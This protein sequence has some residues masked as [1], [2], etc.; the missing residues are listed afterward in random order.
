MNET[1]QIIIKAN[2]AEA[3]K[4][5]KDVQNEVKETEKKSDKKKKTSKKKKTTKKK[6]NE[7][8]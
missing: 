7:E 4:A 3:Q 8:E 5:L 6:E 1:L 2:V